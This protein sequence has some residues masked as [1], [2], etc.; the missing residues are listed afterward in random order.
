[1]SARILTCTD[2]EYYADPCERPS[3]NYST[4]AIMITT[5]CR[6]AHYFHPK[7]G[8]HQKKQT[9]SMK[10][11][12]L[13]DALLL[14]GEDRI[15]EFDI[16]AWRKTA[17]KEARDDLLAQRMI[18]AKTAEIASARDMVG[19][20]RRILSADF[21]IALDGQ[22]QLALE[23]TEQSRL[24]PVLCRGKLDHWDEGSCT[25]HDVKATANAR[26]DNVQ[27]QA[28][29]MGYDIQAA[30]Y[31]SAVEHWRPDLAGRVEFIDLHCHTDEPFDVVPIR[32]CGSFIDLG[33]M[34]WQ[35][36]ID[37]WAE[38]LDSGK[39]PGM[40]AGLIIPGEAPA[41]AMQREMEMQGL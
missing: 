19:E 10:L 29:A 2:E 27:R 25:I 28:V 41:Y 38:C 34:R 5:S 22:F 16:D 30:A 14:G 9:G 24:G 4:A 17:D 26:P 33:R 12:A 18:P 39:W 13:A 11:G 8:G 35:R 7:L 23:W 31:I 15:V 32:A 1:M 21:G 3:L 40:A 6:A 37:Q 20:I 36:A